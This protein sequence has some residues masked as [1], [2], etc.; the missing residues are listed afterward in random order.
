MSTFSETVER[1]ASEEASVHNLFGGDKRVRDRRQTPDYKRHLLEAATF[2]ADVS[3]GRR[4]LHHLKEAMGTSDFPLLFADVLDRQLLANYEATV[5]VWQNYCRRGTVPDFRAVKRFAVDGAE[6][7]LP[8]VG[9]REEYPEASLAESKDEYS[10]AKYGRRLDLTWEALVNDDLDAFRSIP[11]RLAKAA[12]RSEDKFAVG[13]HVDANGPHASLY[14]S[15]NKNIVNAANAGAGFSANNPPL[16]VD[17][18]QQAM[19]VLANQ[20]DADG[21]PI[22]IDGVELVVPPA[23]EV[24]ANNIVNATVLRTTTKG[25]NTGGELEVANWLNRKLRVSVASYIPTIASTANGNSSWFLFANPGTGRPALEVGFLRGYE[26]PALY[27]RAPNA[28]RVGGGEVM[29][30]FEDDS[31]AWRVR[32]VFGGTRLTSTGGAKATVASNGSGS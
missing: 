15:G 24:V 11:D 7:T 25:G 30:S 4:P 26:Q 32:H 9:Q 13:L 14:T 20:K 19:V 31:L 17:A 1:I 2:I 29:E 21:E 10:V 28:R 8:A 16:S 22:T 18:I 3:E 27:E 23:L 6:A 12:R 5:P